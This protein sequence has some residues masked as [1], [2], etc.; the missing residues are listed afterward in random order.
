MSAATGE[1]NT[2]DTLKTKSELEAEKTVIESRIADLTTKDGADAFIAECRVRTD[3]FADVKIPAEITGNQIPMSVLMAMIRKGLI[4][5]PEQVVEQ[6]VN[7]IERK[8]TQLETELSRV[9]EDEIKPIEDS[10]ETGK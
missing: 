7:R 10:K 3:P 8:K 5:S 1:I 9:Q 6:E 4:E 2:M